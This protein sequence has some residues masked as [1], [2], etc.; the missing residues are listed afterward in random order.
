MG[1]RKFISA[2][3]EF[4][5]PY[6]PVCVCCGAEKGVDG[7]LCVYCA[8]VLLRLK[9]GEIDLGSVRAFSAY[10]YDGPVKKIVTGFKYSNKKWL[11][12]FMGDAMI[13]ALPENNAADFNFVCG[14]PL[15]PKKK[16][17]RGF[18]QGEELGKHISDT[19]GLPYRPALRRVKNTK[20]QTKL[21]EQQRRENIKGAF[22]AAE[23]ISGRILL[24]D[25]VLTTGA[26]ALECAAV[27]KKAGADS[28]TILTFAKSNYGADNK[29]LPFRAS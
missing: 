27:L 9:A 11:S 16:K 14:V 7:Y 6:I 5:F 15:H 10:R 24:V 21:T 25:D 17:R 8:P 22:E 26:T 4:L 18:D 3:S 28:V 20:T 13:T 1:F 2:L 12:R 23:E 29:R 19:S